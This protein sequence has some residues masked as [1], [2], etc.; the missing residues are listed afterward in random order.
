M[1]FKDILYAM[2]KQHSEQIENYTSSLIN[3]AETGFK[4]VSEETYQ[5]RLQICQSCENYDSEANKCKICGCRMSGESG[6]FSK[7]R[8]VNERCHLNPPKWGPE[9]IPN[10]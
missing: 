3:Y 9:N 10:Q 4:N 7:L 5:S 2:I 6:F 1:D 8:M